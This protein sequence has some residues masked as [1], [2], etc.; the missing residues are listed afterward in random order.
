MGST[1]DVTAK[2]LGEHWRALGVLTRR[3]TTGV[4]QVIDGEVS[5]SE[6]P[7]YICTAIFVARMLTAIVPTPS[8]PQQP[9][10][11]TMSLRLGHS[12]AATLYSTEDEVDCDLEHCQCLDRCGD[13]R[14]MSMDPVE[15]E[16]EARDT[17]DEVGRVSGHEKIKFERQLARR[18]L[19]EDVVAIIDGGDFNPSIASLPDQ[20]SPDPRPEDFYSLGH[21]LYVLSSIGCD[22]GPGV[23][24]AQFEH[25]MSR[26]SAVN[27][28]EGRG[29]S[30]RVCGPYTVAKAQ[31]E[32]RV[33]HLNTEFRN[34]ST[35]TV[36]WTVKD[37][38][39]L[40][41]G[42]VNGEVR[43]QLLVP[44]PA[45]APPSEEPKHEEPE[46]NLATL[47]NGP[48]LEDNVG[49]GIYSYNAYRH[50]FSESHLERSPE[51][52]PKLVN[53]QLQ[54]LIIPT[55]MPAGDDARQILNERER[56]KKLPI[57]N[58]PSTNGSWQA[59]SDDRAQVI[60]R[61]GFHRALKPTICNGRNTEEL[62]RTQRADR[63]RK[64][65]HKRI[66]QAG[67]I[68]HH[69]RA[70]RQQECTGPYYPAR[71][72]GPRLPC[73]NRKGGG[74]EGLKAVKVDDEEACMKPIDTAKDT[75]QSWEKD[76]DKKVD[77]YAIA[78][79]IKETVRQPRIFFEGTL[80]E[81]QI[82]GLQ[83][84]VSL[85]NNRLNGILADEMGL[86]KTIQ[87]I[88]FITF[89]IEVKRQHVPYLVIVPLSTMT[90]W[91]VLLTTYEYIIK[92][93]PVLCKIK[94]LHMII[95]EGHR[96]KNTQSKLVQTLTTSCHTRY[97]LILTGTP[98]QNNLPELWVLLNF[99]LPKVFNPVKSFDERFNT[100]F[101]NAGTGDKIE[102]NEEE[103]LL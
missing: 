4:W 84:M 45:P 89:L 77:C 67:I 63:E 12:S 6:K 85:Y 14:S 13:D 8:S 65:K 11:L 43:V 26:P 35:V 23:T 24:K 92:D 59:P 37:E 76:E 9:L 58:S 71:S 41:S 25:V 19:K 51:T 60:E 16:P 98:P 34:G 91:S 83:W 70:V 79:H 53:T 3:P 33:T 54:R 38:G 39:L 10:S 82:K 21:D 72:G 52:D 74:K 88:S 46:V 64:A 69:G 2:A 40:G 78:H 87:T 50:P 32:H 96:M 48:F 36:D 75:C 44:H 80:K 7:G 62:V 103:A 47:S 99:V 57:P 93:L 15:C 27:H 56:L 100:P 20:Q 61:S 42:V 22:V 101:A 5:K 1:P 29:G 55:I 31:E 97:R 18:S 28:G 17:S 68:C 66:E 30:G 102:P 94:W 81:Y 49:S 86:G 73:A 90:N 95:D